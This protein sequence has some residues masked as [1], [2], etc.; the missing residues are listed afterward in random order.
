MHLMTINGVRKTGTKRKKTTARIV[1]AKKM[2]TTH[3]MVF[4]II[5]MPKG[6]ASSFMEPASPVLIFLCRY[7]YFKVPALAASTIACEA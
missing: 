3:L 6:D 2:L 7:T 1:E 5:F 4:L